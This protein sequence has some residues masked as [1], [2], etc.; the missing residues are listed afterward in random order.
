MVQ[1]DTAESLEKVM[2]PRCPQ[3]VRASGS[4]LGLFPNAAQPCLCKSAQ[5]TWH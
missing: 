4:G 1:Q 5:P 3:K 2:L